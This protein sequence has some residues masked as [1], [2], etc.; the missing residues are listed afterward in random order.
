[1]VSHRREARQCKEKA[2]EEGSHRRGPMLTEA[3]EGKHKMEDLLSA[4]QGVT[5]LCT[6]GAVCMLLS[7]EDA[8]S[9]LGGV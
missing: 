9:L 6:E 3:G 5:L 8:E 4:Q 2:A 7:M 1:M